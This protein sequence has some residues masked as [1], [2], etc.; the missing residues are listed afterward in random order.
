MLIQYNKKY[1]ERETSAMCIFLK[2]S[3]TYRRRTGQL[4][5]AP[6]LLL[7]AGE[8]TQRAGATTNTPGAQAYAPAVTRV[9]PGEY[10]MRLR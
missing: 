5:R 10:G 6:V 7:I 2:C 1:M 8:Q 9:I 4:G 3:N